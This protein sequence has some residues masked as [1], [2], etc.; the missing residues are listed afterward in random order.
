MIPNSSRRYTISRLLV[1]VHR[2]HSRTSKSYHDGVSRSHQ[3]FNYDFAN[4]S[5]MMFSDTATRERS[6]I[7]SIGDQIYGGKYN[8]TG[9]NN[10]EDY[11]HSGRVRR[12]F[13]NFVISTITT[14]TRTNTTTASPRPFKILGLQQ[15]AVGSIDA[16]ALKHLWLDIFGLE[17]VG[18]YSSQQ[19][20]VIEDILKLGHDD[21]SSSKKSGS[22]SVEIDLMRPID[23]NRSP[24]V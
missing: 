1:C 10:M 21:D 2:Q 24:K 23:E 15:V 6:F 7:C 22:V 17:K 8:H 14:T 16:S 4:S 9:N 5:K 19:E 18:E 20:N 12:Q 13:A 3:F 11:Q